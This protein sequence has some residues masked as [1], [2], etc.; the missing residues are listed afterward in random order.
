MEGGEGGV[1][2]I[3]AR[4]KISLALALFSFVPLAS[5]N[6]CPFQPF[7][8]SAA[9]CC[10]ALLFT[11]CIAFYFFALLSTACHCFMLL[12]VLIVLLSASFWCFLLPSFCYILAYVTLHFLSTVFYSFLPPSIGF[13]CL[14]SLSSCLYYHAYCYCYDILFYPVHT[15]VNDKLHIFSISL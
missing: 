5:H 7:P 12:C 14:V 11:G 2:L 13:Y 6:V 1:V 9:F 15:L 10:F 4:T 8:G 3:L